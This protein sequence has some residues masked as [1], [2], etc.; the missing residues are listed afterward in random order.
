MTKQTQLTKTQS[1]QKKRPNLKPVGALQPHQ[2]GAGDLVKGRE[3]EAAVP[4]LMD[5]PFQR[6][7]QQA[8]FSQMGRVQG[9]QQVQ[10]LLGN[11]PGDTA[12]KEAQ[13]TSQ[14]DGATIQRNWLGDAAAW[15]QDRIGDATDSRSDEARLDAQEELALFMSKEY[16][17]KNFHPDTGRGLFDAKYNP[18]SGNLDITVRIC[19]KFLP[20]NPADPSW[21]ATAGGPAAAAAYTPD[22]FQWQGDET[23]DWKKQAVGDVQDFWS[24]NYTFHNTKPYWESLPNVNVK[25]HVA[26]APENET[27]GVEKAQFVISVYKWPKEPDLEESITPP[28]RANQSVG[29]FQES[30]EDGITNPDKG[31]FTRTTRT[32]A[33]YNVV[34]TK[35]P[36][37]IYFDLGKSE[38]KAEDKT[39][40]KE[41]GQTLGLPQIPPFPV[42]VEGHASSEGDTEP[43]MA[44]SEDRARL[45][46][47]EIVTG[48]AKKQ[49][50]VLGKGEEGAAPT[51]EWRHVEITVGKFESSQH[52]ILHEFGHIFGLGDEYPTADPTAADPVS[53]RPVGTPVAHSALAEKL[54]PGQQPIVAH[55]NENIMSNGEVVQPYH[56][57]TF[58]E[59]LGKMTKTEGQW[60]IGPGPGPRGPGDFPVNNKPDGP[61]Y[62]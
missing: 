62:A 12:G 34:D 56:Y 36:G 37:K 13:S 10:R 21:V 20:G 53:K 5:H 28:G 2:P 7:Q 15:V 14:P 60:Q 29:Q 40:L 6:A 41:F 33:A 4:D 11:R 26:E 19:F 45:V 54:I 18:A 51:A 16:S 25:I 1:Y 35:N 38:L 52:T 42:T 61:A 3:A 59:A 23:K 44:L 32:R 47:N 39:K 57:V 24:E 50:L 8:L 9:N 58:L 17:L 55:H 31:N 27:G 30:A 46:S 49:P 43:N 22:Q 48:G